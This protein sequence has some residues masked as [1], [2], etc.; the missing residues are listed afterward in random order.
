MPR[1]REYVTIGICA[2]YGDGDYRV[3]SE[4]ANLSR[5]DMTELRLAFV[6]AINAAEEMWR[7]EQRKTENQG[8]CST[9]ARH[10]GGS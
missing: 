4:V 1:L 5:K 7:D 8:Q 10:E 3:S 2:G 6:Y 9:A